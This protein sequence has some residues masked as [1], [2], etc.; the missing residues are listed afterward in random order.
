MAVVAGATALLAVA[1]FNYTQLKEVQQEM[2]EQSQ[3]VQQEMKEQSQQVQ[4]QLQ[5]L[6]QQLQQQQ[7]QQQQQQQLLLSKLD[8]MDSNV[9]FFI[10]Q[11]SI[12][13]DDV[14][15]LR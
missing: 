10:G 7:L 14:R 8:E 12:L 5:Q 13:R 11:T 4:Q 1:G 9:S 6:Q 15:D 2:K 3:Q